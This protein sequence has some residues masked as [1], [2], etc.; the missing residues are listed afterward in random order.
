MLD[1]VFEVLIWCF[2]IYG[3]ISF[4]ENIYQDYTYKR[5]KKNIK[6]ILAVKDAEAGIENYIKELKFSN[7]FFNN[8]VI[9]DLNSN[10]NTVKILKELEKQSINMKILDEEEG[11][12]YLSHL[13]I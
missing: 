13:T 12:E 4:I 9:I 11:K 10:D 2:L 8:L 3:I 6:L 5:I 7:N 1:F